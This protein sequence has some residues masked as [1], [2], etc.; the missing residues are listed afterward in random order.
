MK[1]FSSISLSSSL[2]K[3]NHDVH[4]VGILALILDCH[5]PV[6]MP[7][8]HADDFRSFHLKRANAFQILGCQR[9]VL[10]VHVSI[11]SLVNEIHTNFDVGTL[12]TTMLCHV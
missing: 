9:E 10:V 7:N 1:L 8:L 12:T 2:S 5:F 3:S 6:V 11:G 4:L